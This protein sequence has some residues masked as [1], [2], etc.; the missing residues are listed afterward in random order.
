MFAASIDAKMSPGPSA[1]PA[2]KKS[3]LRA[4]EARRPQSERDDAD[5]V[6]DEESEVNAASKRS[7][8]RRLHP[9]LSALI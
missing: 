3:L 7:V 2:T 4:D 5:G 6:D 9:T 1:R 8:D